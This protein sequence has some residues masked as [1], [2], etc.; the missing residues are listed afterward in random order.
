MMLPSFSRMVSAKAESE[1][2]PMSAAVPTDLK[3]ELRVSIFPSKKT[4][5]GNM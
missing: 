2:T 1:S 3:I 5:G 4:G